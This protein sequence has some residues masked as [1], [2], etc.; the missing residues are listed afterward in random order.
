MSVCF[1][2]LDFLFRDLLVT[3]ISHSSSPT[4]PHVS[5]IAAMLA[6]GRTAAVLQET[7]LDISFILEKVMDINYSFGIFNFSP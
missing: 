5:S 6:F 1:V 7:R 4:K 2:T 3:A